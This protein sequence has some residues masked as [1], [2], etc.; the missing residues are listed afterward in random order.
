VSEFATLV[1]ETAESS[2]WI[3]HA[4]TGRFVYTAAGG[5]PQ[6]LDAIVGPE[7]V[8]ESKEEAGQV[9]G[10][11][12]C[13]SVQATDLAIP[14]TNAAVTVDSVSYVI[15]S[16][17]RSTGGLWDLDLFRSTMSERSRRDYRRAN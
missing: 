17:S 12:R 13:V 4:D 1:T 8:E 15:R 11:T 14:A 2:L 16:Y 3:V 10:Y 7:K 9:L 6:S 5:S